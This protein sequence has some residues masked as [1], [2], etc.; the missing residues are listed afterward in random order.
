[1]LITSD[2]IFDT[3]GDIKKSL[4]AEYDIHGVTEPFKIN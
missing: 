1:M 2:E 4:Y 3:M